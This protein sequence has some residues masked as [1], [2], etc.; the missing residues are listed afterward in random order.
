[1]N[2]VFFI[3]FAFLCCCLQVQA[4][5]LTEAEVKAKMTEAFEL[6]TS[7]K[8]EEALEAFL[9]VG[10]NTELQRTETERQVYVCSQTMACMCY[11]TLKR[12]EEAYLLAKKLMSGILT[13]KE[14]KDVGHLYAMNGCMY[15]SGFMHKDKKQFAKARTILE[16]IVP[17]AD[18]KVR[19]YALP[20]IPQ[21]WY[22]EGAE[23]HLSQMYDKALPC[24]QNALKGFQ[25]L[26]R[27]NDEIAVLKQIAA[28]KEALYDVDGSAEAY[29]QALS[30]ARQTGKYDVQ[31]QI[32]RELWNIGKTTGDL[33]MARTYSNSMD[34]L[35]ETGSDSM[36]KYYYYNQKGDAAKDNGQYDIAE[37]WYLRG[38]NIAE[39]ADTNTAYANRHLNL[40]KLRD[41]YTAG[42][43]YDDALL[44]AKKAMEVY[45][46]HTPKDDADYNMP[47]MAMA[48]IYRLTGD[49]ENC[50]LSLD[51]LFG[52]ASQ[53]TEPKNLYPLYMTRGR[54][55]FAFKDYESALDDYKKAD[56]LL[57]AKYPQT[58]GNRIA[59]LALT[60]GVEHQLGNHAESERYY[61]KYAEY[62]KGLYGENSLEHIN[63]RIYLA[64]AEGFA[65]NVTDGC[66][67]YVAAELQLKAWMKQRVPYMSVTEREGLWSP[68]SSLFTSMTPYALE[69]EQT[70][71]E[72]TKNC[73]DALVMSKAFLLESE[74]SMYD[75]I[76]RMGTT[77]DMRCYTALASMKNLVKAW[78]KD[79]NTYADSILSVSRK[80]S[81]LESLLV[82][83]CKEYSDGTDFMDVDYEA[84]K[85][86]LGQNEV[87][88]DFTDFVSK[89]RGR[90]YA[91][92]IINK[93]QDYPLLKPLFAE[94][95]I[96]S[97][98]ITRPDMYY[99]DEY[100][101]DVL[102]LVWEPLKEEVQEGATVYYVP[103]QLLFQVLLESLPMQDGSL[104]GSHYHFVRLSSA[105]ELVK[106]KSRSDD[107]KAKTAVLYGGLQYDLEAAAMA[108]ESR[109]YDLSDLL[110]NRG[111]V[112]RGDSVFHDLWGTKD[113]ITKIGQI[114]KDKKWQVVSYTG[115][116]GTEESFFNMHG[117]SPRLLHLATHGFYY[118]PTKAESVDYLKGYTDAM[119]LSGLVMSGGN[120]EWLGKQLPQGV[121]GGILTAN[122]ISRLDLNGTDMVV[123][124]AC[125]TGQGKAT[126]EGLYGLQR[127]F[128]KAGVGTIV[129]SLWNVSD[130]TASEFMVTFY[131]RLAEN[132]W[133]KRKSFEEAKEIIRKKHPDAFHWAAFVMLD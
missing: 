5:T 12:Y 70:Q 92:Y 60:G 105:R 108:E 133:D 106:M 81:R 110:D 84:V 131:E 113:E 99:S 93:V 117:K 18:G 115:K 9:I 114:L 128:K 66:T 1:M 127:A 65:G 116:A 8:T 28:V 80:V 122:D 40:V 34:S 43:R 11:E 42:G 3:S 21:T 41:L 56:A 83:R 125:Q 16:E 76:K 100:S 77:E 95:Q 89:T 86:A 123:L 120:A 129:M 132:K 97:L 102:R 69:A 33:Q 37:Q 32:L 10:K 96:D 68:L 72:F 124:S 130:K 73:Y 54:C 20:K 29:I 90:R 4:Q 24:Y 44:Y 51:K 57:A 98:G 104:L 75:V 53:M 85:Q 27:M 26:G 64:N 107:G 109:K 6:K 62:T 25:E 111:D 17:Y 19:E 7:K 55:R 67:D 91:A 14:K 59:L 79:Y 78:E 52:T 94:R 71:T 39:R 126:P 23:Y 74:R 30:L 2:K 49:K 87:L 46:A 61:R 82:G 50:Y 22:F 47:Y 15:A 36:A 13:E 103:S 63:A 48:D 112:T 31:M 121:L 35:V 38:M 58:D 118:T 101:E 119:S 45:Q 88:I